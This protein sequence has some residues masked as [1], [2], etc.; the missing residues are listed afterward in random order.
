MSCQYSIGRKDSPANEQID[1]FRKS[2]L[3]DNFSM[4]DC[5]GMLHDAFKVGT[6]DAYDTIVK[7]MIDR[8]YQTSAKEHVAEYENPKKQSY[9]NHH[10]KGPD[11][12]FDTDGMDLYGYGE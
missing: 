7:V 12:S 10:R 3:S 2:M 9:Q 11:I 1:N 4:D 5:N 8:A 6:M